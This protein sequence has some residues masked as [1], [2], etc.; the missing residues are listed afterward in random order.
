M[1]EWG[2]AVMVLARQMWTCPICESHYETEYEA[3]CCFESHAD[4]EVERDEVYVCESCGQVFDFPGEAE[5]H[6]ERCH[7]INCRTCRHCAKD[8]RRWHPCPRPSFDKTLDACDYYE[9]D[10]YHAAQAQA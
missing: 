6:E 7:A 8:L 3:T 1:R 5:H 4:E 9:R 2:V 10:R